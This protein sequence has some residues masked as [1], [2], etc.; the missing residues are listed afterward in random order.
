MGGYQL[1]AALANGFMVRS[2][3]RNPLALP[4]SPASSLR[5]TRGENPVWSGQFLT[6]GT[7]FLGQI[8]TDAGNRP[9]GRQTALAIGVAE[10][11]EVREADVKGL[12]IGHR[13]GLEV[14]GALL[15]PTKVE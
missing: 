13:A 14:H 15:A 3:V 12:A 10:V 9:L 7:I 8:A 11:S 4:S 5:E 1:E 6:K 2:I